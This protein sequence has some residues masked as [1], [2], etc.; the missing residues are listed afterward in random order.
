MN[1]SEKQQQLTAI[2]DTVTLPT[3]IELRGWTEGDFP[4]I[5]Q[6][7]TLQGWPTPQARPAEALAAW[8]HSWPTLVVNEGECIVGFV[9][10]ITD[11][12]ITMYIAELLVDP[13]YRGHGLGHLLLDAC[14]ALYPQTRLDLTS[15]EEAIPFYKSYGFHYVGEGL[16]KSY[17]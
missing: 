17:R 15:T 6:L 3:G 9:R 4:A 13:A 7:S 16:R 10:S 12:A 14:H 1:Y 11:G 5:Q 8:Q 2:L